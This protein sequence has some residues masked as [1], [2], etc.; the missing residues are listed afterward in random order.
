MADPALVLLILV[1]GD[2]ADVDSGGIEAGIREGLGGET[3]LLVERS[4]TPPSDADATELA[5]RLGA[6]AVAEVSWAAAP[7]ERAHL[8]LWI[9]ADRTFY[10]RDLTFAA[11]DEARERQ[12]SIGLLI[13]ATVRVAVPI[14]EP[15][16]PAVA[17]N[18]MSPATPPQKDEPPAPRAPRAPAERL[19]PFS[20]EI[21]AT[22]SGPFAGEGSGIGPTVGIRRLFVSG[23]G[24]GLSAAWRLGTAPGAG[25]DTSIWRIGG[26]PSAQWQGLSPITVTMVGEGV[27]LHESVTRSTDTR[28][29]WLPGVHA[30]A[31]VG[32]ALGWG[33]EPYAG[34]GTEIGFGTTR[35]SVG[36]QTIATLSSVHVG[37]DAGVRVRF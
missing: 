16:V 8:H 12:V 14:A 22:T 31:S 26:G 2:S 6:A 23:I 30:A 35:V 32:W 19:R 7:A 28:A 13:A 1:L 18:P 21:G 34:L 5:S 20:A 27:V 29:R 10:D 3:R 4:K 37:I 36:G 9:G 11:A 25:V 17:P 15:P 33:V 24:G